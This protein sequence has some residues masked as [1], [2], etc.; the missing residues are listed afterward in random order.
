MD[1]HLVMKAI[2][3]IV[4]TYIAKLSSYLC[5]QL[6]TKIKVITVTDTTII[7]QVKLV[8]EV[9]TNCLKHLCSIGNCLILVLFSI[10]ISRT[11]LPYQILMPKSDFSTSTVLDFYN[12]YYSIQSMLKKKKKAYNLQYLTGMLTAS[13]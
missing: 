1:G 10:L 5:Q 2:H 12:S 8:W 3:W 6:L 7:I 11:L 9:E 13:Y 4:F